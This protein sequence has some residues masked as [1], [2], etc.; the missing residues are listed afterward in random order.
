MENYPQNLRKQFILGFMES[1][2]Y[3][4]CVKPLLIKG[5]F[6]L[7]KNKLPKKE[8][9]FWIELKLILDLLKHI[10]LSSLEF[11]KV[12]E[13]LGILS[14]FCSNSKRKREPALLRFVNLFP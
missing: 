10:I 4:I 7:E 11:I 9:S 5:V 6:P 3:H 13:K 8:T 1:Y 14:I 2:C 12:Y